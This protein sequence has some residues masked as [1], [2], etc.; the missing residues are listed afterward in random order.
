MITSRRERRLWVWVVVTVAAIY[1]TLG[2][3]RTVTGTLRDRD[4]LDAAFVAATLLIAV[5]VVALG[6][7]L[8]PGVAEIAVVG[9]VAAVYVLVLVRMALPEE[10]TH[11]VEYGVVA[12]LILEALRERQRHGRRVPAAPLLAFGAASLL[13]VVDELIQAVVPSRVFDPVDMFVNAV[14]AG[15]AVVVSATLS[16][17]RRRRTAGSVGS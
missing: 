7:R 12:V 2:L 16:W 8:R 13:G 4:L 10:R 17:G 15:L 11:L 3:A 1:A 9:A 6:L 5:A 14:A